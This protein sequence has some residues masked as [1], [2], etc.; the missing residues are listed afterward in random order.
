MV[1]IDGGYIR[2]IDHKPDN[3]MLVSALVAIAR[4]FDMTVI[5][6]H[7]ENAAEARVLRSLEVDGFQGYL[8]GRPALVWCDGEGVP[9]YAG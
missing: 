2:G 7:V 8:F 1:K 4:Q 6:E 3:K 5:A 9:Q